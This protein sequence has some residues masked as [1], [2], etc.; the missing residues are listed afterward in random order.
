MR[1]INR[2]TFLRFFMIT[3]SF[4]Y[5]TINYS[6][7]KL[8]LKNSLASPSLTGPHLLPLT[9]SNT[10]IAKYNSYMFKKTRRPALLL[11]TAAVNKNSLRILSMRFPAKNV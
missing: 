11:K 9:Q 3:M 6:T 2:E 5:L 8:F 7:D 10:R 1:N 4:F